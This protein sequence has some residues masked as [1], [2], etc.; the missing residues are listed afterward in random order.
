MPRSY[1]ELLSKD[2]KRI[3]VAA[4]QA[5][6]EAGQAGNEMYILTAGSVELRAKDRT[7]EKVEPGG[8]FGEMALIDSEPRSA[9]AIALTDCELVPIDNKR[10]EFMLSRMPFFATEVMRVMARRLRQSVGQ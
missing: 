9:S 6:F 4:G 8:V 3:N 10:F 2:E 5:V 7:L 1:F